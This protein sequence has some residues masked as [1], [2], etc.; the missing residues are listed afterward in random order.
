MAYRRWTEEPYFLEVV[1]DESQHPGNVSERPREE[2]VLQPAEAL[3]NLTHP[4]IQS[5]EVW[6]PLPA[7]LVAG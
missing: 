6:I 3:K 4:Q 5:T 1:T 7:V 2:P